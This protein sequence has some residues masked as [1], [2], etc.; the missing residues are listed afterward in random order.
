MAG[1][2]QHYIPRFLQ[3]GFSVE[4]KNKIILLGYI[5]STRSHLTLI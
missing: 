4:R 5:G 1:M 2:R 3:S